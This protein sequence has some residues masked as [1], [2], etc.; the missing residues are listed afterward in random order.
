MLAD[1]FLMFPPSGSMSV[2][3]STQRQVKRLQPTRAESVRD[4][5]IR[6]KKIRSKTAHVKG[7]WRIHRADWG[8]AQTDVEYYVLWSERAASDNYTWR[9]FY[10]HLHISISI[11]FS[12]ASACHAH[13]EK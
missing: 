7:K 1:L 8:S 12:E 3:M 9:I 6:K 11:F 5:D 4:A 13:P 2:L 10:L